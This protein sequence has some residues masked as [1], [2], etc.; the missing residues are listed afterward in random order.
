M[1]INKIKALPILGSVALVVLPFAVMAA[2]PTNY[3]QW[4]LTDDGNGNGI[5]QGVDGSGNATGSAPCPTTFSSCAVIVTGDGFIQMTANDGSD[6]YFW[7]IITDELSQTT[8]GASS[9]QDFWMENFVKDG[10]PNG[11][12]SRQ[13]TNSS[14]VAQGDFISTV[15]VNTGW[16]AAGGSGIEIDIIQDIDDNT[17]GSEFEQSFIYKQKPAASANGTAGTMDSGIT[18]NAGEEL[19]VVWI[20]Q[21]VDLGGTLGTAAADFSYESVIDQ[22]NAKVDDYSFTVQTWDW[23]AASDLNTEFGTA[24]QLPGASGPHGNAGS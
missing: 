2:P 18:W 5:I 16:G 24:P 4:Y 6:T 11:I 12:A 14:S 21:T 3:G 23:S 15:D 9:S 7:T 17:V 8:A 1:F 19:T 10:G 13:V 22:N 20:G